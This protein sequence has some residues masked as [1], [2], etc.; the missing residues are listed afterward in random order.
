[1]IYAI[2]FLVCLSGSAVGFY[3]GVRYERFQQ[4]GIGDVDEYRAGGTD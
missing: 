3:W 2:L 4:N 1:M